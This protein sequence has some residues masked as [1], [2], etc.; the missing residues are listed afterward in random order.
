MNHKSAAQ[1]VRFAEQH[2]REMA[3]KLTGQDAIDTLQHADGLAM[4]MDY[5]ADEAAGRRR[6]YEAVVRVEGVL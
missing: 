6:V 2:A 5:F 3:P 4:V 1:L